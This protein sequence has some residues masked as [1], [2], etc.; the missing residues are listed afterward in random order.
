MLTNEMIS[1]DVLFVF[2]NANGV[3]G[4]VLI[5]GFRTML[6]LIEFKKSFLDT[7]GIGSGLEYI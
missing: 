7:T 4:F 6:V 5:N 2:E 1:E 3:I